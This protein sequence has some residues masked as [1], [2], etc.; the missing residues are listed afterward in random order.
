MKYPFPVSVFMMEKN[1]PRGR[2]FL[3]WAKFGTLQVRL[4]VA[5]HLWVSFIDL[6]LIM[7]VYRHFHV[8]YHII[9]RLLLLLMF[10]A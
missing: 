5:F 3:G 1:L 7:G 2:V 9:L 10:H 8:V 6:F 4:V